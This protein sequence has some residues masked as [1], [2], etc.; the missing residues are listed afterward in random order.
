M[1]VC[2]AFCFKF[3]FIGIDRA[4]H[5]SG[6]RRNNLINSN[7]VRRPQSRLLDSIFYRYVKLRKSSDKCNR[8][9]LKNHLLFTMQKCLVELEVIR[10]EL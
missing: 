6:R 10:T 8:S 5:D 9:R 2:A 7:D 3:L 1:Q 4:A